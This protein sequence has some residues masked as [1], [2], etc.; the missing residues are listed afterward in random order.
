MTRV[1]FTIAL[2]VRVVAIL[3][4]G[5]ETT[6][7]GDAEAYIRTAEAVLTTGSYPDNAEDLP[8]FRA[9][10]YSV[11]LLVSTL[12]HPR[13]VVIGKLWNAILGAASAIL[14]AW[15]AGRISRSRKVA[16]AAGLLA[17]V[18]PAFVYL[19]TDIQSE[20]LT[21]LFILLSAIQLLAAV[22]GGRS[23]EA[24]G[25]GVFL[26]LAA[27]TRPSCLA[28]APLLLAPLVSGA[29]GTRLRRSAL[30]VAGLVIALAP[31]TARNAVRFG[32][33][34]PVND[35]LGMQ[36]W[37]GNTQF[38][39]DYYSLK[40]KEQY[41][42]LMTRYMHEVGQGRIHE[43]AVAHPNPSDRSRAFAAD[44]IVWIQ[45]NFHSWL[46]LMGKKSL[47]WLRPWPSPFRW[48]AAII[49]AVGLWYALLFVLAGVGLVRSRRHGVSV[50]AV[51]VLVLSAAIHIATVVSW[52]YRMVFWDPVLVVFAALGAKALG[53]LGLAG[54]DPGSQ[55]PE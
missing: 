46:W 26:G 43:I 22:G 3:V 19:A 9:P 49:V 18:N 40:T 42:E 20:C 1:V 50:A 51:G 28:I 54:G 12:G 10:G 44:A 2:L 29:A 39:V 37:L 8:V 47:D 41:G 45:G 52:R 16:L 38:N 7:F 48:D 11:F 6:S 53:V 5:P 25:A 55:G 21:I 33:F 32:A 34:V 31:W 35:Q 4:A 27:L 15:I 13:A 24:F 30:A 23:R 36:V 17:A 14:I